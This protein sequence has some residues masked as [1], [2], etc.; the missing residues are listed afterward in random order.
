M[1][2][3]NT[4][5]ARCIRGG[6]IGQRV[7]LQVGPERFDRVQLRGVGRQ[8]HGVQARMT[9]KEILK[10]AGAVHRQAVPEQ[11][12]RVAEVTEEFAEEGPQAGGPCW[13]H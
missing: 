2:L 13:V 3:R 9:I 11:H 8:Q 1:M 6:E 4:R 10:R 12:D 7:L 5:E